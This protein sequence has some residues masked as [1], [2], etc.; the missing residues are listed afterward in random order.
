[1]TLDPSLACEI[2]IS[3]DD[4]MIKLLLQ[5]PCPSVVSHLLNSVW[6]VGPDRTDWLVVH[7]LIIGLLD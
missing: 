3:P 6:L 5:S 4:E 7:S 2:D 1:M